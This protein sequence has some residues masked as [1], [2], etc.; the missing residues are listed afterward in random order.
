MKDRPFKRLW[1][2]IDKFGQ[3]V[4]RGRIR[5]CSLSCLK[6]P[7]PLETVWGYRSSARHQLAKIKEDMSEEAWKSW[8]FKIVQYKIVDGKK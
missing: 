8:R 6:P 5:E 1:I 4:D 3:I 7:I 2:I